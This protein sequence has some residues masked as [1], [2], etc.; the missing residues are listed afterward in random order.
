MENL[1]V[2]AVGSLTIVITVGCMQ[3]KQVRHILLGEIV[4]NLL[5]A[6]NCMAQG[7][8]TGAF[9]CGMAAVLVILIYKLNEKD[10]TNKQIMK[11]GTSVLYVAANVIVLVGVYQTWIDIIPCLTACLFVLKIIQNRADKIRMINVLILVLWIY[12]D[13]RIESYSNLITHLLSLTSV[14]I[15]ILRLDSKWSFFPK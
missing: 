13:Y 12:Y 9:D 7:G 14:V 5:V 1:I 6:F 3:L 11:I 2:R 4:C 15:A 10:K 8:I